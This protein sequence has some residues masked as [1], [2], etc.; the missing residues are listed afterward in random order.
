MGNVGLGNLLQ[1]VKN[2]SKQM[3]RVRKILST[4]MAKLPYPLKYM[5]HIELRIWLTNEIMRDVAMQGKK[6]PFKIRWGHES[7]TPSFWPEDL[8]AWKLIDN[9][10]GRQNNKPAGAP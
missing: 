3:K 2:K 4:P 6:P 7:C 10:C 9:P 1:Q 8:W 5:N